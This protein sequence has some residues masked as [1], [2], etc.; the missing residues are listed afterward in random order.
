MPKLGRDFWFYRAGQFVSSIGDICTRL[1]LA[2]WILN[3]TGSALAMASIMGPSFFVRVTATLLLGPLGDRFPR[4]KLIACANFF[5][6]ATS[7][8]L[9]LMIYADYFSIPMILTISCLASVG[10]AIFIAGS[11]GLISSLVPVEYF[12]DAVAKTRM[13]GSISSIIGGILGGVVVTYMGIGMAFILDALSFLAGGV[14]ALL[15]SHS[16]VT[17]LL[18]TGERARKGIFSRWKQDFISNLGFAWKLKIT[19]YMLLMLMFLNLLLSQF[20]ILMPILAKQV[21]NMPAWYLGAMETSMGVGSI[22]GSFMLGSL[23]KKMKNATVVVS[24]FITVG[25]GAASLCM[26]HNLIAPLVSFLLMGSGMTIAMVLVATQLTLAIPDSHRA[27]FGAVSCFLTDI[28]IPVGLSVGGALIDMAGVNATFLVIGV[29]VILSVPFLLL[30]PNFK[31]F[32]NSSAHNVQ[33]LVKTWYPAAY[34]VA[35]NNVV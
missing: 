28:S 24:G 17:K 25:V 21:Q 26:L 20:S 5:C 18:M 34:A 32:I 2:W 7:L 10:T 14:A 12:R 31:E 35:E 9:A 22:I 6:A 8:A 29:G 11:G 27:R 30:I 1:A 19:L 16:T 23:V 4:K 13:L 3:K 33:A 15:I